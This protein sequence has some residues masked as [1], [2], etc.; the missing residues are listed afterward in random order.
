MGKEDRIKKE[1]K[2]RRTMKKGLVLEGGAMRGMFTCGV[3]D[4]M[5]ENGIL[6][7]GCIGVSAGA[8]F[9]CNIKSG[10]PGRAVRY[11]V[12]LA[13]N[14]R[15]CSWASWLLTGSLYGSRFCYDELPNRIDYW[16]RRAFAENPMEFI[17]VA[18][19]TA[20][21]R[22]LYYRCTDGGERDLKWMEGSASMP[23]VSRPVEVD[24]YR[25][26]DGGISDSIPL[27]YFQSLGYDR[28]IV[29]LTQPASYRKQPFSSRMQKLLKRAL[30]DMPAVYEDLMKRAEDYN[31]EVAYVHAEEAAGR[32]LVIQPEEPLHISS[33]C[34]SGKDK[35]RVYQ[36][37]RQAGRKYLSAMKA[38]YGL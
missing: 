32:V 24:G 11:N 7:E 25:L 2:R 27:S 33:V 36:L 4:V 28:C 38:F 26:L 13:H 21:G 9:G 17:M 3:T 22:P 15:Y 23:V 16:D 30:R 31:R 5:M 8:C 34:H 12:R 18:T 20:T 29:I 1:N 10:Q 14:W 19:D 6:P 35:I 37:G